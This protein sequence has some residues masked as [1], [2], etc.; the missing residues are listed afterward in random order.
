MTDGVLG[1]LSGTAIESAEQLFGLRAIGGIQ[2]VIDLGLVVALAA[3]EL[4]GLV[5]PGP[6]QV[7]AE[8]ADQHILTRAAIEGVVAV[9]A[10]EVI[11][12]GAA[13][14]AVVADLAFD[15]VV[16]AA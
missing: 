10:V 2:Q 16:A 9:A 8:V 13:R 7:I 11:V 12:A 4:I 15:R 14:E 3:A 1:V 5:V 6:Q